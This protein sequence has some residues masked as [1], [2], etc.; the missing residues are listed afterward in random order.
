MDYL[1]LGDSIQIKELNETIKQ[2]APTNISVLITGESGTGKELVANSIHH[3][4]KRKNEPLVKVNCGAIP[5]G[6][7]ESELFG[8]QKG[9][10]TGAIESRP[11][12]FEMAN[13][14]SIFL[15]EIG[16]LPLATQVKFL[17]VLETGE[18]MRVGGTSNIKVD[19][20]AIA[21]TNK[22]LARETS[23]KNF[24]EDLY[25]RLKSINLHIPPL[26]ERKSDIKILFNY[27]IENYCKDNNI[28]F[29]GIDEEAMEYVINYVWYG[30]ARELRNFCESI[31]VLYPAQRLSIDDVKKHLQPVTNDSR[32]LPVLQTRQREQYDRDLILRALFELKTD[33]VDIK[34]KLFDSFHKDTN[35][36]FG[37]NDDF[38]LKKEDVEVMS[39]DD[40]E[41]EILRYYLMFYKWNISSVSKTLKQSERN[42]YR[43]IK[44]FKIEKPDNHF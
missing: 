10:F 13:K 27:F 11:G 42:I 35:Y 1:L 22:D 33:I 26:R 18:F 41:R 9:A 20:R 32:Q 12:Y 17:R 43:K 19:V 2:V 14:G 25:F 21:A 3:F 36:D 38:V 30:N 5:E 28:N 24:R 7:I 15:D 37:N 29:K 39:Y 8:H 34:N 16:E 31:I 4:S 6:I 44:K 23:N 40:I